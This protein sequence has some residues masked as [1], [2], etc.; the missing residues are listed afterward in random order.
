MLWMLRMTGTTPN[1]ARSPSPATA[2]AGS[3]S[4]SA[5]SAQPGLRNGRLEEFDGVAG[6]IVHEDLPAAHPV[7]D[8]VPE[9]HPRLSQRGNGAVE[10]VDLEREAIPPSRLGNRSVRH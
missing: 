3:I 2:P 5:E 8:L 7:H 4:F 1:P 9:V 6:G 10:I